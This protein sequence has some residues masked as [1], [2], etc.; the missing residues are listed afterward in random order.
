MFIMI[1]DVPHPLAP[2]WLTKSQTVMFDVSRGQHTMK[3]V[4][5]TTSKPAGAS[6][7]CLSLSMIPFE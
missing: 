5:H 1:V 4:R 7:D 6:S 2:N 3:N